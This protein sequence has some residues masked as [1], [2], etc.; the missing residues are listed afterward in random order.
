MNALLVASRGLQ[1]IVDAPVWVVLVLKATAILLAAWLVHLAVARANPRWRGFLWR[2]TAVSL[3]ALPVIA[4]LLPA[5]EIRVEQP[6]AIEAAAVPTTSSTSLTDRGVAGHAP[7]GLPGNP[8]DTNAEYLPREIAGGPPDAVGSVAL[9]RTQSPS[10]ARP[11]PSLVTWPTLLLVVW[12]GGI[13]V[14][15]FRLCIGHYRICRIACR[16]QQ[17]TQWIRSECT[18]VVRAIGCRGRVE[19]VQSTDVESPFLCGLWRPRLLLPAPMCEASYRQ[20]LPG[21]LAHE[22]A[23]VRSHDLLW[24]V[25]L[26]LISIV[27]WFHPL[28]WRIRKVHLAACE[29]VCDAVSASFVGDVSEYCRI[30]ARVAV[31]VLVPPPAAGIGMARTSAISRRLSTLRGRVFHLPLRRRSVA[32]LCLTA[33]PAV[34]AIGALQFALAASPSAETVAI[35]DQQTVTPSPAESEA[36]SKTQSLRVRVVDESGKPLVGTKLT[37]VYLGHKDA[38]TTDA[39]GKATV[40]VPVP[41]AR[42]NTTSA[43]IVAYPDGYPPMRKR[44]QNDAG[45]DL[46]PAEFTFAYERGRT[47]GGVVRD[48]EGKPIQGVKVHLSISSEKYEQVGMCLALWDQ[49]FLTDV[50]GRWDLGHVPQA[51]SM[52]VGLGHPDY[53]S[54][55]GPAQ[56]SATKQREIEDRTSVM[57]MKRGI[58]VSGTVTDPEGKPVADATVILGEWYSPERPC[59]STDKK[60]YYRFASLAPGGTDLTV[61]S[62]GLAPGLRSV[63]VQSRMTPVDFQLEKGNTLR[64]RV[65]GKDGKPISGVFVTP[66]T[67]RGKR[68]L[69]DLEIRGRTDAEGRWTWTWAPKDAVKTNFGLTGRVNYMRIHHLPLAP[70]EAEHVVT[71]YRALAISGSVVDAQ[72]EQP[73]PNFRVVR[74]Y[75]SRGSVE[76]LMWDR[77]EAREG[78]NGR[79]ELMISQPS[80]THLVRIEADGYQPAVSREFKDD[81]GTVTCDFS[82]EKGENLNVAVRLSDGN[83]AAG[84]DVRLCPEEPGKS[85]NMALFVKNGRF[86]Y[87]DS[88]RPSMK[89]A[90]DG[91]LR[92]EPQDNEFLLIVLHDQGFAQTTSQELTANPRITLKAWA[93]LEGTVRHGTKPV[94]GARLDVYPTESSGRRW[95]FLNFQV[96]TEADDEG[97]FVFAKLKPGKW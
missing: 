85:V 42:A 17:P 46:I 14:L 66:D 82:L 93:R 64:V 69:C 2:V 8:S 23:H 10:S 83:P 38:Y 75:M 18:R 24:N 29:L 4:W 41:D 33:L 37:V 21:I 31:G 47:I 65:V 25:G 78:K 87:P 22:M 50:E 77:R 27:L 15:A 1:P 70:Q 49:V 20:E 67:W 19:V 26:Q 80:Q 92:I 48:E 32:A 94:P 11:K 28:V 55:P 76:Q 97:K 7:F 45:N 90:A 54:V 12:L 61:T 13:A 9:P 30:L 84:A 3:I 95:S 5:L 40:V 63:N 56:I 57:V 35:A 96:Q 62:P 79:Y 71:L 60:G 88:T 34:V 6:P 51:D 68:V 74:G 39:E 73:I 36:E 16:A 53:I 44:W 81:D 86:P 59:V 89:V 58:P 43:Y 52:S 72:T 91:Q